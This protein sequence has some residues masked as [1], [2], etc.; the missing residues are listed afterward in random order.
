MR[1][2]GQISLLDGIFKES[3]ICCLSLLFREAWRASKG[4]GATYEYLHGCWV[5]SGVIRLAV[6]VEVISRQDDI[7]N[8]YYL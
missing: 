4:M 8:Q 6:Y 2:V 5:L 3:I 7:P 1:A